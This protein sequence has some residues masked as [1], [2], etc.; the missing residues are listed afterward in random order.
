MCFSMLD[1]ISRLQCFIHITK[2]S[3]YGVSHQLIL[4][5]S[6]PVC[7]RN[8]S[9]QIG[10]NILAKT[11]AAKAFRFQFWLHTILHVSRQQSVRHILNN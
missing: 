8:G 3:L 1:P 11:R 2:P 10:R 4:I 6:L 5:E 7:D 9:R